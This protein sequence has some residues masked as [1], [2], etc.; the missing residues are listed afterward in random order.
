MAAA[1]GTTRSGSPLPFATSADA[2]PLSPVSIDRGQLVAMPV[3]EQAAQ[4]CALLAPKI[5]LLL[6]ETGQPDEYAGIVLGM[7]GQTAQEDVLALLE[8]PDTL[9]FVVGEAA[10]V[11]DRG[12]AKKGCVVC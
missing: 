6:A 7:L 12:D 2:S 4:L 11:V 5:A 1:A 8:S 10:K 3:E 9:R